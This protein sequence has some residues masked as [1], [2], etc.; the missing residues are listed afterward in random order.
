L[1][2]CRT[3]SNFKKELAKLTTCY[4]LSNHR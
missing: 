2:Q 1:R 4:I 3:M